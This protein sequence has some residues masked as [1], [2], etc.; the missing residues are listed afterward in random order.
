MSSSSPRVSL[1]SDDPERKDNKSRPN[2]RRI[3]YAEDNPRKKAIQF[4]V[5]GVANEPHQHRRTPSDKGVSDKPTKPSHVEFQEKEPK[6]GS[7]VASRGPSPPP[8][9]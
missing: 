2:S 4:N 6:Q 5:G 8:P 7:G 3:S 9:E 1:D